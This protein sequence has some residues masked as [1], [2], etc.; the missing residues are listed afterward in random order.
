MSLSLPR[1]VKR[2]TDPVTSAGSSKEV[3]VKGEGRREVGEQEMWNQVRWIL[4]GEEGRGERKREE[5]VAERKSQR[6]RNLFGMGGE[7]KGKG[8]EGRG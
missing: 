1:L 6:Y 4:K 8:K 5:V 3:S 7:K 2:K